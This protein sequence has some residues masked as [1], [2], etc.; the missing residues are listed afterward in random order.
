MLTKH[1]GRLQIKLYVLC[2]HTT[3]AISYYLLCEVTVFAYHDD[4]R[5]LPV[6]ACS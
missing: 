3:V 2:Q 6:S 4:Y 5:V 1:L